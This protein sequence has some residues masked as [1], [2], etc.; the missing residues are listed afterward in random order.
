MCNR[1]S[2]VSLEF[3]YN[4]PQHQRPP[5]DCTMK[6]QIA[7][8]FF[9]LLLSGCAP[10]TNAIPGCQ[11]SEELYGATNIQSGTIRDELAVV[12][13]TDLAYPPQQ[14]TIGTSSGSSAN[15]KQAEY[16]VK[17]EAS[18]GRSVEW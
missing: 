4:M 12:V 13:W 17:R 10:Y 8:L 5:R 3:A 15:S 1:P 11:F 7:M 16:K 9:V 18:D 6:T 2:L 14:G